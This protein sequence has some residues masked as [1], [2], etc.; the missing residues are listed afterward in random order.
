MTVHPFSITAP[1]VIAFSPGTH[2]GT[3][4]VTNSGSQPLAI[5]ETLGRYSTPAIRYPASSHATLTALGRPWLTVS[6]SSFTIE[7]GKSVT[8]HIADH[9]PAGTKGDHFLSVVWTGRP[10]HATAGNL[11][12][13]GAVATTVKVIEPGTATAVT[14]QGL[15]PAPA[16]PAHSDALALILW[17]L[18]GMAV[19]TV[20]AVIFLPHRRRQQR[21]G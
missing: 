2:A 14:A 7:P 6:P 21:A 10:A 17:T 15:A 16:V 9:V 8:V 11:H 18:L 13:T 19:L 1:G 3:F 4:A 12:I 20:L 5:R